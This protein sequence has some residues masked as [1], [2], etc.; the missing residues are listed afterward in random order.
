MSLSKLIK[1]GCGFHR[2]TRPFIPAP[3]T[4]PTIQIIPLLIFS[5]LRLLSSVLP[6]F[7]FE[8]SPFNN[9]NKR[10]L[11]PSS[12][13]RS[14]SFF[15]FFSVVRPPSSALR[16]LP[17]ALCALRP[18]PCSLRPVLCHPYA[19]ACNPFLSTTVSNLDAGPPGFLT[20]RSQS[21]TRFFDTFR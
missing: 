4:H 11:T 7:T 9:H 10:S 17:Y 14:Q 15:V 19:I 13:Q 2:G 21:E 5:E 12:I 6:P 3:Y 8:L 18:A 1:H 20:P 16:P